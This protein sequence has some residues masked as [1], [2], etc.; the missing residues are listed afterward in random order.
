MIDQREQK[1]KEEKREES[2]NLDIN[3]DS[4]S[5]INLKN[6]SFYSQNDPTEFREKIFPANSYVTTNND[7]SKSKSEK[8]ID[9]E[10][11]RMLPYYIEKVSQNIKFIDNIIKQNSNPASKSNSKEKKTNNTSNSTCENV[12]SS[13]S[14]IQNLV[15]KSV[16]G[17]NEMLSSRKILTSEGNNSNNLATNALL[18]TS[19][20][21]N[22]AIIEERDED[23]F[24][25]NSNMLNEPVQKKKLTSLNKANFAGGTKKVA[26]NNLTISGS[27]KTS[28]VSK[29]STL[30]S[31]LLNSNFNTYSP[32]T[33]NFK[34]SSI[35]TNSKLHSN[36]AKNTPNT[37]IIAKKKKSIIELPHSAHKKNQSLAGDHSNMAGNNL[38]SSN[39]SKKQLNVPLFTDRAKDTKETKEHNSH[40]NKVLVNKKSSGNLGTVMT[41]NKKTTTTGKNLKTQPTMKKITAAGSGSSNNCAC[42]C[43]LNSKTV[44]SGISGVSKTKNLKRHAQST[45]NTLSRN[46][47]TPIQQQS[48]KVITINMINKI[49]DINEVNVK[50]FAELLFIFNEINCMNS[51]T[52]PNVIMNNPGTNVNNSNFITLNQAN[53]RQVQMDLLNLLKTFVDSSNDASHDV[54]D[55]NADIQNEANEVNAKTNVSTC[56]NNTSLLNLSFEK[57]RSELNKRRDE[58]KCERII[59]IQRKWREY[60]I[61]K[62]LYPMLN[63]DLTFDQLA[64]F[65][66]L[67]CNRNDVLKLCKLH[68]YS[69]MI[70]SS[71]KFKNILSLL[72]QASLLWAELSKTQSKILI[73]IFR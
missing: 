28:A 19:A 68:L 72:H 45:N 46:T 40:T 60:R 36:T 65:S 48:P 51:K 38:L 17:V 2:V 8:K 21:K 59:L 14:N 6:V 34:K 29:S 63:L 35:N 41:F 49:T 42:K 54:L 11:V 69:S 58:K 9:L 4:I 15:R 30:K 56:S 27:K 24:S 22:F 16:E 70:K 26:I 53:D 66:F 7:I 5:D 55:L 33:L 62:I 52:S 3:F 12:H 20:N 57:R 73:L 39:K 64:H 47:H 37:S 71:D 67:S 23:L 32:T 13:V 44:T 31:S 10:T 1:D 50:N 43:H 18:N 61:K 25:R